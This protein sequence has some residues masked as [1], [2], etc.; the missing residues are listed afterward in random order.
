LPLVL[1]PTKVNCPIF[2]G[3]VHDFTAKLDDALVLLTIIEAIDIGSGQGISFATTRTGNV[4]TFQV[5]EYSYQINF[6]RDRNGGYSVSFHPADLPAW[7]RALAMVRPSIL[8]G[9]AERSGS[10]L[11]IFGQVA[12]ALYKFMVSERPPYLYFGGFTEKLGRLYGLITKKYPPPAGYRLDITTMLGIKGKVFVYARADVKD[13]NLIHNQL[14]G[15]K[16][17]AAG[18]AVGWGVTGGM[19]ATQLINQFR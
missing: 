6:T 7:K 19:A 3:V 18:K 9:K 17:K 14:R 11:V 5:G 8:Y 2:G 16:G 1:L 10:A 13:L 15:Q 12:T 4:A